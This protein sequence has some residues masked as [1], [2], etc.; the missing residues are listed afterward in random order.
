MLNSARA[1]YPN[2]DVRCYSFW[3]SEP[4]DPCAEYCS[5]DPCLDWI[6][7]GTYSQPCGSS[8][9]LVPL[10]AWQFVETIICN[11]CPGISNFAGGQNLDQDSTGNSDG[12]QYML[13]IN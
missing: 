11:P 10:D 12:P 7:F 13:I 1:A 3:S 4:E 2:D 5:T 6:L 8:N 9:Y